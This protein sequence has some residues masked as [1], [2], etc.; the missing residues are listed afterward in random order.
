MKKKEGA[1]KVSY[2]LD[3]KVAEAL[4]K[5]CEETG[6]TKTKVVELAL[7]EYIKNHQEKPVK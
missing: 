4:D 1:I 6:R 3:G 5:F 2:V 7:N